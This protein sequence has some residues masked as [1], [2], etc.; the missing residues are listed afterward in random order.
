MTVQVRMYGKPGCHLCEEA[1][2]ALERLRRRQPFALELVDIT[3]EPELMTRYGARIPVLSVSG[4]EYDAPL[5]QAVLRQA[6]RQAR[7]ANAQ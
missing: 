7:T 1:L 3:S 6:L 5:D 4:Y 2:A